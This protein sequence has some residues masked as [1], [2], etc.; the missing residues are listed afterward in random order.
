L[1]QLAEQ[2]YLFEIG[3][4]DAFVKRREE[5]DWLNQHL[6]NWADDRRNIADEIDGVG[7]TRL[8]IEGNETVAEAIS[9]TPRET[10]RPERSFEQGRDS[11]ILPAESNYLRVLAADFDAVSDAFTWRHSRVKGHFFTML[12][13]QYCYHATLLKDIKSQ[14]ERDVANLLTKAHEKAGSHPSEEPKAW[15][16]MRLKWF[17]ER[18]PKIDSDLQV[19]ATTS[20]NI[21]PAS[22]LS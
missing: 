22:S 20:I 13:W 11:L 6:G 9:D 21:P 4:N 5:L 16:T 8:K 14:L 19:L 10:S 1:V 17:R 18:A 3:E 7:G 12:F 15:L 2:E